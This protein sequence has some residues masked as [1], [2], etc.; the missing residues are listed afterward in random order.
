MASTNDVQSQISA[1]RAE[2]AQL[3]KDLGERGSEAYETIRDRAG[4][5]VEAARPAVRSATKYVRN[6]GAAVAQAARE[7]PAALST[8]VLTAGLAGVVLGYL[9]GSLESEPPRR[10]RWF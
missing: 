10:Q 6:E 1:L 2:I 7:H 8:V 4:N 9:L 5:A 3:Q